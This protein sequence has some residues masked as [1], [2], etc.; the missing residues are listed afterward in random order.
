M[1]VRFHELYGTSTYPAVKKQM[2]LT[3]EVKLQGI[4][5]EV[6]GRLIKVIFKLHLFIRSLLTQS[7]YILRTGFAYEG[8]SKADNV[9]P[10]K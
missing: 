9:G 5:S 6:N 2:V 8:V 4:I 1:V 7:L 10:D 3:T